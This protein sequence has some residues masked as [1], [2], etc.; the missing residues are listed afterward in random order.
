MTLSKKALENRK[1][2]FDEKMQDP[3]YRLPSYA[4][5]IKLKHKSYSEVEEFVRY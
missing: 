5:E 4:I 2:K 1:K 3:E